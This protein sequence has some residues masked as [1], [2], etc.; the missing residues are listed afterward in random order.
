MAD[1]LLPK[2]LVPRAEAEAKITA[3][4]TSGRQ[5]VS[6]LGPPPGNKFGFGV[7]PAA[8]L[9]AA[10][11]EGEKWAK[12]T[13]DL[14][15]GLVTDFRIE[16]EFGDSFIPHW[17]SDITAKFTEWMN[18]RLHRLD[19]ILGRLP[20]FHSALKPVQ[21]TANEALK[22]QN[23]PS[24]S[25]RTGP[26][27]KVFISWSGPLC[28][29]VALSLREWLPVVLPCINPWVSSEDITKGARWGTEL[30]SELEG[31]HSGIICLVPGYL[32]EP[33]LIF[34]AGA[35]SKSVATARI[36]PFLFGVNPREVPA[37]LAQFQATCF[38]KDDLRKLIHALNLETA[39]AALSTAQVDR[40]FD[41]C[42]PNLESRLTPLLGAVPT[43]RAKAEPDTREAER[44]LTAE[45]LRVLRLVA[46]SAEGL[47]EE[48]ADGLTGMHLQRIK[49][50]FERLH[51]LKLL[52]PAYN[53]LDGTTWS[54]S[55]DG[56]AFLVKKGLL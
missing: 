34:E 21:A 8:A 54:L 36:H 53:Y 10:V 11:P 44:D 3:Q 17:D 48:E 16:R 46:D 41:V 56:R 30:A 27:T 13:I 9:W 49:H 37:P 38:S 2:L 31:T 43:S 20:L 50:V 6:S 52:T 32:T 12:F 7:D 15:K 18:T 23:S 24:E 55:K 25:K 14:L 42:W 22:H 33:W 51:D 5:I 26:H 39:E 47:L 4:I 19:S 29:S 40:A 45:E 35:L 1:S 28:H